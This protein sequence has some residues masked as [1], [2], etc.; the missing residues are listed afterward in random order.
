MF[1]RGMPGA[2]LHIRRKR[3]RRLAEPFT[4]HTDWGPD[5]CRQVDH[6]VMTAAPQQLRC[7]AS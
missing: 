1:S 3:G 4:P 2:E 6:P 7:N 5:L